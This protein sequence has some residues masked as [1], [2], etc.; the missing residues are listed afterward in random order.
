MLVSFIIKKL[1]PKFALG[2]LTIAEHG[3]GWIVLEDGQRVGGT[4]RGD[5]PF[6]S[7]EAALRY[8]EEE[9]ADYEESLALDEF[10]LI[11]RCKL[12]RQT[13]PELWAR[14]EEVTQIA[15]KE[16]EDQMRAHVDAGTSLLLVKFTTVE[17]EAE[18]LLQRNAEGR[19]SLTKAGRRYAIKETTGEDLQ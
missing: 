5:P 18:G 13:D 19:M 12:I 11:A 3:N 2:E 7:R 1:D 14:F 8:V 15:D 6:T 4:L 16:G 10:G 17:L 9:R